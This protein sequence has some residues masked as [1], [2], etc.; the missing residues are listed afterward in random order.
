MPLLFSL[1]FPPI[2]SFAL[3]NHRQLFLVPFVLVLV[4]LR[5]LVLFPVFPVP[6]L[7]LLVLLFLLPVPVLDLVFPQVFLVF[8][9]PLLFSLALLLLYL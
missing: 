5:V 7:L 8:P 3:R 9:L 6:F 2:F 4:L 1:I